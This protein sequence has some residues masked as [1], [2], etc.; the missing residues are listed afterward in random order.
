MK[1][2]TNNGKRLCCFEKNRSS[3]D[4]YEYDY[5]SSGDEVVEQSMDERMQATTTMTTT[6]KEA[7][8]KR[9]DLNDDRKKIELLNN[10]NISSKEK[11]RIK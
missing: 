10:W 8:G 4:E 9:E 3:F 11:W 5:D 2:T 7:Q 6:K 1:T